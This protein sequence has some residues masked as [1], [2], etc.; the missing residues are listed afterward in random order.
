MSDTDNPVCFFFYKLLAHVICSFLYFG[1]V[2]L[3]FFSRSS[4]YREI[5]TLS[6][7]ELQLFFLFANSTFAWRKLCVFFFG[8]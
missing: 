4:L 5:I 7:Y 8:S 6:I 3:F 1:F 2:S